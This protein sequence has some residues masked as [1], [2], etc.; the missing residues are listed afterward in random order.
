MS[1]LQINLPDA[2]SQYADAQVAAGRFSSIHDYMG[3]LVVADE[4]AQRTV[5]DLAEHP[6]LAA[7]LAEGLASGPGRRWSPAVLRELRDQALGRPAEGGP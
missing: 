3:A 6:R 2:I 5:A 4:Q 1:E 7:L